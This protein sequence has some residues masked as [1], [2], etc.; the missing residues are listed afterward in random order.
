MLWCNLICKF[1]FELLF[2]FFIQFRLRFHIYFFFCTVIM[3]RN[4][5]RKKKTNRT[6]FNSVFRAK[7]KNKSKLVATF[8]IIK[9]LRFGAC[10]HSE[11][12]SCVRSHC[13]CFDSSLY[14]PKLS[15]LYQHFYALF[16]FF[17]SIDIFLQ[18]IWLFLFGKMDCGFLFSSFS[19][20]P[21]ALATITIIDN[22]T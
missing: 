14:W 10:F 22:N 3:Y 18:E 21:M 15:N 1:F 9:H 17:K 2:I 4:W 8:A 12:L 16:S 20:R 6:L 5:E 13:L 19:F 11:F 7:A